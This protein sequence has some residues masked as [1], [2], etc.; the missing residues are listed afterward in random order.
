MK[1]S[2]LP[3]CNRQEEAILV[4]VLLRH[5]LSS[6]LGDHTVGVMANLLVRES[7]DDRNS[8]EIH[9]LAVGCGY[10]GG[11]RVDPAVMLN[12]FVQLPCQVVVVLK[13]KK[14]MSEDR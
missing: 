2:R 8:Y 12:A 1:G 9:L 13:D 14:L 11:N 3:V 6:Q 4:T 10:L 5:Q 7:I